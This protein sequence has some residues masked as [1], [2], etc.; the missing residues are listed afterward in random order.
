MNERGDNDSEVGA[1]TNHDCHKT[2][3]T[4]TSGLRRST[5][6]RKSISDPPGEEEATPGGKLTGKRHRPLGKMP[7]I[8]RSPDPPRRGQESAQPSRPRQAVP[9]TSGS[10]GQPDLTVDTDPP[11]TTHSKEHML[12]LGGMRAVVA[13]ELKKTESRLAGRIGGLEKGF[14]EL[15]DDVSKLDKRVEDVERELESKVEDLIHRRVNNLRQDNTLPPMRVESSTTRDNCYWKARRS[16][17]LWPV[18]GEG[19]GMKVNLMR[20]LVEKLRLGEDAV[21]GAE[22]CHIRRVPKANNPTIQHEV[23][24]EFPTVDLR[25]V[26]RGAAYNLANHEDSGIR[27]EIAHHLMNNFKALNSASY[28]IKTRFPQCKRNIKYDDEMCDL[29]LEFRTTPGS[30][31]WK[32][33]RPDQARIMLSEEGRAEEMSASDM[34]ELLTGEDEDTFTDAGGEDK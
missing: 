29:I 1:N 34:S 9:P 26:V 7:G 14:E 28:R 10:N 4:P 20:F 25:D 5:R 27:L 30:G 3:T 17:R 6:K 19:E 21:A 15:K 11:T 31:T 22:D 24:V 2:N 23:A 8:N 33:L 13:D 12:L 16:L 18:Q 32:R